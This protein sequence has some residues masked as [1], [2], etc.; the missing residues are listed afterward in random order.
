MPRID[1]QTVD[2]VARLARLSLTPEERTR[3]ARERCVEPPRALERPLGVERYERA[4]RRLERR[5]AV[6]VG[7]HHLLGG[8]LA[9]GDPPLDLGGAE[10][11][12]PRH[13]GRTRG[14]RNSPSA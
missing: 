3:F 13:P 4:D 11:E 1:E 9:P 8:H 10:A 5:D 7:S 2:C 14:T 12:R 6:E